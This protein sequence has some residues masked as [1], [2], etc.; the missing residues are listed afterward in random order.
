M[1]RS[2]LVVE[3]YLKVDAYTKIVKQ[4]IYIPTHERNAAFDPPPLDSSLKE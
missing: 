1:F 2:R 4:N 3:T